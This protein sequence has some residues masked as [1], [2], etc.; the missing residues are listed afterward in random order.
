MSSKP[1]G[2]E[3]PASGLKAVNAEETADTIGL[4]AS[5]PNE[6]SWDASAGDVLQLCSPDSDRRVSALRAPSASPD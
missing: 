4:L 6:R 2:A 5:D 3:R 1:S